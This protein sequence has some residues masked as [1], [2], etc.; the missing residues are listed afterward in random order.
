MQADT[1]T[2][3]GVKPFIYGAYA[4]GG[5]HWAAFGF[6]RSWV[7]NWGTGEIDYSLDQ[8]DLF[9]ILH[10]RREYDYWLW[11]LGRVRLV[12][13]RAQNRIGK[14]R[15]RREQIECRRRRLS[16]TPL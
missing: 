14:A 1:H 5:G 3:W 16:A 13:D 15:E 7:T 8:F 11:S 6:K 10:A 12:F 4:P 9:G 2:R